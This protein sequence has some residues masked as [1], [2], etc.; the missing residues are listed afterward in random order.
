MEATQDFLGMLTEAKNGI[1]I[2][3]SLPAQ[4]DCPV[5]KQKAKL[6]G[7][8]AFH[9]TGEGSVFVGLLK[10]YQCKGCELV[11]TTD[12]TIVHTLASFEERKPQKS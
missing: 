4:H 5:C 8:A 7:D 6:Y 9:V 12:H 2:I 11:F 1:G 10:Y 3:G